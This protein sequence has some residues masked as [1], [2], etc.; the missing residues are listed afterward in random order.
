MS[1]NVLIPC[2]KGMWGT[3]P[4]CDIELCDIEMNQGGKHCWHS[5]TILFSVPFAT[6]YGARESTKIGRNSVRD[7]AIGKICIATAGNTTKRS[8]RPME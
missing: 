7:P 4:M 5:L 2:D 8:A 1:E 6:W 3:T